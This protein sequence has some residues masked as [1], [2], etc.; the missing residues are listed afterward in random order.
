MSLYKNNTWELVKKPD[1]R[2]VVD[3]KWIFKIKDGLTRD[4][5][6]IFKAKLVAKGYTQREG[7]NFKEVFSP[8][9]RHASIKVILALTAVQDMELEGYVEDSKKKSS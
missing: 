7:V 4:E 8:I 1:K 5:P 2:R 3:C 6:K 9:V